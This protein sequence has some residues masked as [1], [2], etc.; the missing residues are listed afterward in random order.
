M[1]E[2]WESMT[3]KLKD[4]GAG[5]TTFIAVG[6]FFLYM[7]GYLVLRFHITVLGIATE[8]A[9]LD[10][11]YIFAGA[12]FLVFIMTFVPIMV[13]LL[14][15]LLA[16]VYLPYRI[17]PGRLRIGV[18]DAL[19][20]GGEGVRRC[21]CTG[22]RVLFLG[23]V[24]SLFMIQFVMRQCLSFSNLL[25]NPCLP[26]QVWLRTTVTSPGLLGIHFAAM[27]VANATATGLLLCPTGQDQKSAYTATLRGMLVFL[28]A[29]QW[30]MLPVNYGMLW[31][32]KELPKVE[33]PETKYSLPGREAWL[34]WEGKEGHIFFVRQV[35]EGKRQRYLVT[36]PK[37][38]I[39]E[40]RITAYQ[41]LFPLAF[42]DQNAC[43]EQ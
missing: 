18:A 38:E 31:Y 24:F 35:D 34:V 28:V 4:V 43:G 37:K 21:F 36:V 15:V 12:Q 3:A 17:L 20:R 30:F 40:I 29:V 33:I 19:T 25:V 42:G 39:K 5:W 26:E 7:L 14:L 8:L 23:V 16:I 10:E 13:F 1:A 11:R 2:L 27:I 32:Q 9:V 6:S 22:D 41:G